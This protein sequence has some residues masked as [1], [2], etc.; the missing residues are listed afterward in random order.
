MA[1]PSDSLLTLKNKTYTHTI[2]NAFLTNCL[3]QSHRFRRRISHYRSQNPQPMF[4]QS[5]HHRARS[6]HT[7]SHT[8]RTIWRMDLLAQSPHHH[9]SLSMFT[10]ISTT[11][12]RAGKVKVNQS[13]LRDRLRYCV[14]D[15]TPTSRT[16]DDRAWNLHHHHHHHH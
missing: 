5:P 10:I 12:T 2:I 8:A 1:T 4:A 11:R 3:G 7:R 13:V 6:R 16:D 15:D 14:S 9:N